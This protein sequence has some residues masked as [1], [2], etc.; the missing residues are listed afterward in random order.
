M[1][2][3]RLPLL[4]LAVILGLALV[5][6]ADI[7]PSASKKTTTN[8]GSSTGSDTTTDTGT[9]TNTDTNTDTDTGTDTGTD[10]TTTITGKYLYSTTGAAAGTMAD[11]NSTLDTWSSGTSLTSAYTGDTTY[12]PCLKATQ[13]SGWGTCIAF[14]GLTAG[15]MAGYTNLNFKIKTSSASSVSVKVPE[16]EKAYSLSSGTTLSGGWVQMTIALSDFGSLPTSATQFAIFLTSSGTM[17]LTDVCLS[18]TSSST[19]DGTTTDDSSTE[20]TVSN[21]DLTGWTKVW[22]DEFNGTSLDTTNNWVVETGTGPYGD[23]WGNQELEYYRSENLGFSSDGSRKVMQ[24]TAKQES[25]GDRN[26]TSSRIKTL[27]KQSFTYGRMEACIKLPQGRSLFPAFWMLGA[28]IDSIGWPK[29]GEIDIMEMV[30]GTGTAS[31]GAALSNATTYGTTHFWNDNVGAWN[32]ITHNTS[33]SSGIFASD[34]HLFGVEWNATTITWYLDGVAY[35]SQTIDTTTQTEFIGHDF[36]I[37]FNLA[38]GGT[39]AGTPDS[40]SSFPQTMSIDWV[41]VYQKK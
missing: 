38:V 29:C 32:Y 26:Y 37:L 10:T 6:C 18:G 17:Y 15:K 35:D 3:C 25:Y 7:S 4:M 31:T 30:G 9:D 34:Y 8:N 14:T 16:T 1:N 33:L 5:S 21:W 22:C 13:S 20:T 11:I 19:T 23:G 39:W 41:R 27:G 2:R 24:I 40:T 36:F 12:S 28:N